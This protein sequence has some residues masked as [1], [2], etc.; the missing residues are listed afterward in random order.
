MESLQ[1]IIH[2]RPQGKGTDGGTKEK[3]LENFKP[4]AFVLI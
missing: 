4:I 3:A 1:D 2:E